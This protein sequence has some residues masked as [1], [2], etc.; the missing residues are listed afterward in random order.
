MIHNWFFKI[1]QVLHG[2]FSTDRD[3]DW[4]MG[5]NRF[6]G[7]DL[8]VKRREAKGPFWG[9]CEKPTRIETPLWR[10]SDDT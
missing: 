7:K 8:K 3:P 10:K 4:P 2:T 6:I 5:S 1:L 9:L